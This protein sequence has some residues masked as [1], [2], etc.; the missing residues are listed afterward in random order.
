M[1]C[2]EV[3]EINKVFSAFNFDS[4]T[5]F[6]IADTFVINQSDHSVMWAV[7]FVCEYKFIGFTIT[8]GWIRYRRLSSKS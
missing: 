1:L 6:S 3:S 5:R 4:F 7:S 8:F 2:S